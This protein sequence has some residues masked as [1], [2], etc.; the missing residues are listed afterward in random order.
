MGPPACC[1]GSGKEMEAHWGQG[2]VS[3]FSVCSDRAGVW[4]ERSTRRPLRAQLAAA[5]AERLLVNL[6]T[7]GQSVWGPR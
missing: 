5:G 2:R 6:Q 1:L 7:R 3:L 4:R